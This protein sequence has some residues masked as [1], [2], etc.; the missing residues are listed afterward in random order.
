MRQ[1]VLLDGGESAEV[2]EARREKQR[3]ARKV[4]CEAIAD[5]SPARV[6]EADRSQI[7]LR[8]LDID[9]LIPLTHRARVVWSFVERLDL[10]ALYA[11]IRARGSRPG[12]PMTDPKILLALWLYA[13]SEG[14][15]RARR[16][17]KL[18]REHSAFRWICGGVLM[19]YHTLADFRVDHE[20]VLD[21]LLTQTLAVLTQQ[22]LLRLRRTAQDGTRVRAS[23]GGGS[24]RRRARL[25]DYLAQA[26]EQV[27]ALKQP[28]DE[29]GDTQRTAR[30]QAARERAVRERAERVE[31]A[32]VELGKL[33]QQREEWK[34]GKKP[35]SE[36][37]ASTTDPEAR[38]MKMANGGFQPAYNAQIATDTETR[39][40]VGV[41]ITADGTDYAH[42]APMIDQIETRTGMKPDQ[43]LTDGG[44]MSK[45]TV[46]EV[47]EREVALFGPPPHRQ[48]TPDP[49]MI[50]KADSEAVIQWKERMSSSTGQTIY[51]ER[52]STIETIN[53]DLKQWRTLGAFTV[54]GKRK[55]LCVL[56]LNALAY[57]LLRWAALTSGTC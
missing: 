9:S 57:N 29:G 20:V 24:F 47:T 16:I 12:R 28:A 3:A 44:F 14:I 18:C 11:S 43:H 5:Q 50:Q 4:E 21:H 56:L 17:D 2:V 26:R 15:G 53:G 41:A 39:V 52:G 6:C 27:E 10:S 35:T 8:P 1:G 19:N 36:P 55:A 38:K 33:E 13:T 49:Y 7:E 23:A 25:Q 34:G 46:E 22:G 30:Q 45:R 40:I 32:L 31:Q 48:A 51:K 37:R 54:R 42:A